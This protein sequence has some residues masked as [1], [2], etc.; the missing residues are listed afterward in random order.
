M[1][2]LA[3][4]EAKRRILEGVT[5]VEAEEVPLME[6]A[7]RVLAEEVRANRDQPPFDAS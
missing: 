2:L 3:V 4:E 5:P 6:A 1:G 7:G